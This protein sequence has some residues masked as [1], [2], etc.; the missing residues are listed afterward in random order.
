MTGATMQWAKRL[1]GVSFLLLLVGLVSYHYAMPSMFDALDPEQNRMLELEPG[2]SGEIEIV[3]LGE[4][5]ALRLEGNEEAALRLVNAN[6]V[7][8]DG[9]AP[10]A[11]DFNRPMEDGV[12]Y[13]VV[14]VFR[15]SAAGEYTLHNDGESTL[16]FVDDISPQ[17]SLFTEPWVLMMMVGCCLGPVLGVIGLILALIGWGSRGK[18]NAP[19]VL[20]NQGRLPTTEEL[21][22]H[23]HGIES[24]PEGQ[25]PDPFS[26]SAE[27]E[28][29]ESEDEANYSEEETGPDWKGW[30][31]G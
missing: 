30:D 4:Y 8:D 7:E 26:R 27:G 15:T 14:R 23:Y 1:S 11:L 3:S 19:V 10:T 16:W 6:G 25:V 9:S 21:Y 22:R 28:R 18:E 24:E 17:A 12:V 13:V 31:E 5:S 2:A 29:V 20:N